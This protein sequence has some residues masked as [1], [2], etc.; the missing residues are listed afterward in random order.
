MS[1]TDTSPV[2]A[3]SVDV[4]KASLV[5]ALELG[6][7]RLC[8]SRSDGGVLEA[9]RRDEFGDV[10]VFMRRPDGRWRYQTDIW[11]SDTG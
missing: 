8:A 10:A 9:V 7:A 3:G 5:R 4:L 11:N 1:A 6:D 2:D